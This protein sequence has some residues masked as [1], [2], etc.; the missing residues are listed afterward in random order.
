MLWR[1]CFPSAQHPLLLPH[2][3]PSD[4]IHVISTGVWGLLEM[5]FQ[6]VHLA[7][8]SGRLGLPLVSGAE[9]KGVATGGGNWLV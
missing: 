3:R 8:R 1:V 5:R 9:V 2:E 7:V 4:G 6:S